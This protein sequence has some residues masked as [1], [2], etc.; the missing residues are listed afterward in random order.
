MR[1]L[2]FVAFL[3]GLGGCGEDVQEKLREARVAREMVRLRGC[4]KASSEDAGKLLGQA[5]RGEI[6]LTSQARQRL[7]MVKARGSAAGE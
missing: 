4:V 5:E 2:I 6:C 7:E 1:V 3:L